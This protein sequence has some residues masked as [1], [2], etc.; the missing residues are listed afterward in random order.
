MVVHSGGLTALVR[1]ISFFPL[2]SLSLGRRV[3]LVKLVVP[4]SE[5][6]MGI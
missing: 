1:L 2:S 5:V 3:W 4:R 6:R